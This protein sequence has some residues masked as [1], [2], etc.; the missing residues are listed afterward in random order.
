M[1][2]RLVTLVV[3]VLLPLFVVGCEAEVRQ[4][5]IELAIAWAKENAI[6]VGA[7]TLFGRS[8]NAEVDAVL[9]ARDAVDNMNAADKL[10]EEGRRDGDLT[11]M[12]DAIEKRP[13]DYTYRVSYGSALL[14]QGRSD[15][16]QEQFASANET[17][18]SYGGEHEQRYATQGIDEL[19]AMRPDIE[20]NGYADA[21]QCRAYN[22]QM[23]HFYRVRF[24]GTG[25][26]FFQTKAQEFEALAQACQ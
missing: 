22:Q 15:D 14:Q 24:A 3:I 25:E 26:A 20:K 13:G 16:A 9:G 5:V 11:K 19:G 18:K 23:A 12:E 4:F 1:K 21:A 10:M 17:A 2:K 6:A 7:Y 8:G